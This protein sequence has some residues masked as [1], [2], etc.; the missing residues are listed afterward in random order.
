MIL[1]PPRYTRT[2]PLFPYTTLF[3]SFTVPHHW[4]PSLPSAGQQSDGP[5]ITAAL[6][7]VEETD[8]LLKLAPPSCEQTKDTPLPPRSEERRVGKECVSTGRARWPPKNQTNK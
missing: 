4:K 2:D 8:A 5:G 3:R 6:K 7:L 1:R